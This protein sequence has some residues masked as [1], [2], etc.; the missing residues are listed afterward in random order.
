[1]RGLR[2]PL[3][4]PLGRLRDPSGGDEQQ[5]RGQQ[6]REYAGKQT[7][8]TLGE[9]TRRRLRSSSQRRVAGREVHVTVPLVTGRNLDADGLRKQHGQQGRGQGKQRRAREHAPT[10]AG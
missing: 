3:R 7:K 6:R 5:G 4:Y 1:M 2:R 9:F 10:D 8:G